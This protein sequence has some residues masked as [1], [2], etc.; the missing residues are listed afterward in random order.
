MSTLLPGRGRRNL[1]LRAGC[2]IVLGAIGF[3]GTSASVAASPPPG[4]PKDLTAAVYPSLGVGSGEV[5]LSW[6]RA[7]DLWGLH[8]SYLVELSIDGG[9]KWLGATDVGRAGDAWSLN[10]GYTVGGLINGILYTIRVAA[11]TDYGTGPWVTVQATPPLWPP[12]APGGLAATV[13]GSG[14]VKLTWTQPDSDKPIKDYKLQRSLTGGDDWV[15]VD[16][17]GS[18]ATTS[19]VGGLD[20]GRTYDFRVAAVSSV[21]TGPWSDTVTATPMWYAGAP[22]E[23]SAAVAP[24]AGVG[25]GEVQLTWT[26]P[27]S[28]GGAA[29]TDYVIESST[30]RNVWTTIDDGISAT[31]SST[32][33]GLTNGTT[34]TF[35]VSA[36]N[37]VGV[38]SPSATVQAM[39][40]W[41]PDAPTGLTA[42][43]AP[44]DGVGSGEVKLTWT[45]PAGNG[46]PITDYHIEMSYQ[47]PS[48]ITV[49]D[50]VSNATTYTV[51]GLANNHSWA[52]QVWAKNA[53]GFS[54]GSNVVQATPVGEPTVAP[55]G[56]T[57]AVAP[58]PGATSGE[59][60]LTWD[61]AAPSGAGVTDYVIESSVDGTT[62]T[63]V[64]DGVSTDTSLTVGGLTNG[65]V[66]WFRVAAANQFGAGPASST[67]QATPVWMPAVPGELTALTAPAEGVRSG[68]AQLSWSVPTDNGLE[69]SDYV[70][71]WSLDGDTWTAVDDGVSTA[72]TSTV[73]GLIDGTEY[74]FRV[75]AVNALGQG[76][77]SLQTPAT[78]VWSPAVPEALTTDAGISSGQVQL[79]WTASADHGSAITD[80]LVESSTDGM[81]WTPVDDG[82]STATTST[83]DGLTDGVGYSFRVAAVN[84]LGHGAWS[85]PVSATPVWT[86]DA[87][88]GLRT[89]VGIASG[90]AKLNWTVPADH[91]SPITDYVIER[92]T[93]GTTWTAVSDGVSPATT[94]TVRGLANG[95]SYRF[96]VAADNAVG[97][98]PFSS[99]T[100]AVP[101][102]KPAAPRGLRAAAGAG[103]VRLTW[104]APASNGSAINDYVIQR[105]VG[106]RWTTVRDGVSTNRSFTVTHLTNGVPYRF[107]V[108][109]NNAIGAG[110]WSAAVR[111]TPQ[112]N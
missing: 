85:A 37:I 95:T 110:R 18:A 74:L 81:A 79:S 109:A 60:K 47:S 91:G 42:V 80:Y 24:T 86:P 31:T 97:S 104:T 99:T 102:W 68:E 38:G 45:A 44:A 66:Y 83:V 101:T 64:D 15:T 94:S 59:V 39:P 62:W 70:I 9:T 72:T 21:G 54:Q 103:R 8:E 93:D 87:P 82:E 56:L 25:S 111:T 112:A 57:A 19:T 61:E 88:A 89:G 29:V 92:S 3:A 23:L 28:T 77:W 48:W 108:A 5:K 13:V 34:Y 105:A 58:A 2:T 55:G 33:T 1:W 49:A 76:Q 100:Q 35:R 67:M 10:R 71:E 65:D 43:V 98:S 11:V 27:A 107:R 69:I 22:S 7:D 32:V 73:G 16:D 12:E 14:R 46:S 78:P 90:Q 52:F 50:G 75:A 63:R 26:A 4:P 40:M 17:G 84:A 41:R 20:N 36:T 51:G 53:V 106:K 96:R 30:D 6:G